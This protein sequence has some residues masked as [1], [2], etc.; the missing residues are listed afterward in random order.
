MLVISFCV[1]EHIFPTHNIFFWFSQSRIWLL[2]L[3][4]KLTERKK[5]VFFSDTQKHFLKNSVSMFKFSI[6]KEIKH[7]SVTIGP[8]YLKICGFLTNFL[9]IINCLVLGNSPGSDK[10]NNQLKVQ[11][12]TDVLLYI[13]LFLYTSLLMLMLRFLPGRLN[14]SRI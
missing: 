3:T 14:T 12:S 7:L 6:L 13:S 4:I 11:R 9:N 1:D 8:G 5:K 2:L 10:F